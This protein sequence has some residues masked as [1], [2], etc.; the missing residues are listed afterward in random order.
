MD[1]SWFLAII[2]WFLRI[3]VEIEDELSDWGDG[4]DPL[5]VGL[6]NVPK[7]SQL[8]ISVQTFLEIKEDHNSAERFRSLGR[9]CASEILFCETKRNKIRRN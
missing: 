7:V 4:R 8:E 3:Y 5:P 9:L 1:K 2:L 6:E